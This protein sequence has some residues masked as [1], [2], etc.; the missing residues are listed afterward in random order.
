MKYPFIAA[1]ALLA[2]TSGVQ[3]TPIDTGADGSGDFF[4]SLWDSRSA[5]ITN[6]NIQQDAFS[7]A[8]AAPGAFSFMRDL[9]TDSVFQS[10]MASAN[11]AELQWHV[12]AV[13]SLRERTVH[14]TY[15]TPPS[16]ELRATDGRSM[17]AGIQMYLSKVNVRLAQGSHINSAKMDT[18]VDPCTNNT[19]LART[20]SN[21]GTL[22]NDSFDTG[23]GLAVETYR[24]TGF[25]AGSF[26]P[27]MDDNLQLKVWLDD[28]YQ[29]NMVAAVPEPETYAMLL[30]GLGLM[31]LA[32]RRQR[33]RQQ[34]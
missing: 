15:H 10:F 26:T 30:A 5:Y 17:V 4:F 18:L 7:A 9:S 23:L 19:T 34:A 12:L 27:V 2:V 32:A 6:L 14:T 25:S 28:S 16:E 1:A 13:E 31:G 11:T 8:V 29:L 3:A 33:A 21:C 20:F 22:L 24:V